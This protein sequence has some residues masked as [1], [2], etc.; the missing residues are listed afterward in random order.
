HAKR[1]RLE[2]GDRDDTRGAVRGRRLGLVDQVTMDRRGRCPLRAQRQY[3]I[4]QPR[5]TVTSISCVWRSCGLGAP[6]GGFATEGVA[7][8]PNAVVSP[9]ARSER[10]TC[11]FTPAATSWRSHAVTDALGASSWLL[12]LRSV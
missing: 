7:W 11:Q 4:F 2:R 5:L 8:F 1:T 12:P 3:V 6:S 10:H 9:S